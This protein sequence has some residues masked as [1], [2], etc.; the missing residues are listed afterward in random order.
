[1]IYEF[2][3]PDIGEGLSEAELLDWL[4]GV[5]DLIE[6]GQD[7]A[8]ISTDKVNVDIPSPRAGTV[9]D[10]PWSVGDVIPVGDVFMRIEVAEVSGN[11]VVADNP[12]PERT[13]EVRDQTTKSAPAA[14]VKAPPALR[15][16]AKEVG[17][18]LAVVTPTGD[19][20]QVLR[21]DIDRYLESGQTEAVSQGPDIFKLS[22]ARLAAAKRLSESSNR[23]ATASQS[24]DVFGDSILA[25]TEAASATESTQLSPLAV[26][27]ERVAKVLGS[28]RKFNA[29][30]TD[31]DN[32]LALQTH[33]NLG[34]AVNTEHGLMVPVVP[35]ADQ[36][37]AIEISRCLGDIVG[38]AREDRLTPDDIRGA[39]FTV[40]STGGLEQATMTSTSP[41][42]NLPNVATLWLSRITDR[43][44]VVN[45][46]LQ[47]G[48]LMSCTLAFDHRFIDGAEGQAF[49]NDLNSAFTQS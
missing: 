4:V 36:K 46:T 23:M 27:A 17:V 16:Y 28:H 13:D 6:E 2:E 10:L 11:S 15:R 47:A 41:V 1:M 22:G 14:R 12:Y 9:A 35:K 49:I 40:S 18:D 19:R 20:G 38:R 25:A 39:T 48:P 30:L 21:A 5:G 45:G 7:I 33:V 34:I 37:S 31:T 43:P 32:E 44:R 24:F 26:I 42:I 3:L 29:I 8:S